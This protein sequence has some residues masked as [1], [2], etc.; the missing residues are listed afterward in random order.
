MMDWCIRTS[1]SEV[2]HWRNLWMTVNLSPLPCTRS[3]DDLLL[4][5]RPLQ[6]SENVSVPHQWSFTTPGQGACHLTPCLLER[7]PDRLTCL[8]HQILTVHTER[9]CVHPTE[10]LSHQ[11]SSV[12]ASLAQFKALVLTCR[13][14]RPPP[15]PISD[16]WSGSKPLPFI[17]K[18]LL[19][20]WSVLWVTVVLTKCTVESRFGQNKCKCR[21]SVEW[22]V[23]TPGLMMF[24]T[25]HLQ[26]QDSLINH[27]EIMIS[28]FNLQISF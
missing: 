17:L 3:S 16:L 7:L 10:R 22:P 21:T 25:R 23:V 28:I 24:Y 14:G 20:H 19:I 2:Q 15:P 5:L 11:S 26:R 8:H 4:Q 13:A 12:M 6:H 9:F 1:W 27:V 18:D